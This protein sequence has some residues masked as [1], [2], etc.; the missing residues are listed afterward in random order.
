MSNE[1]T[2]PKVDLKARTQHGMNFTAAFLLF[3]KGMSLPEIAEQF[4]IS[5]PTLVKRARSEDWEMLA[6]NGGAIV[7]PPPKPEIVSVTETQI[8]QKQQAIEANRKDI[9]QSAQ[10]LRTNIDKVLA[11][12]QTENAILV[13]GDILTMA[14]ALKLV[15]EASMLALGDDLVTK[16][17]PANQARGNPQAGIHIHL[18]SVVAAPRK[19]MKAVEE[20]VNRIELP[21]NEDI[22]PADAV[23]VTIISESQPTPDV[24]P[25]DW[26]PE[27]SK[28]DFEKLNQVVGAGAPIVEEEG[29]LPAFVTDAMVRP[30]DK[31]AQAQEAAP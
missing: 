28:V 7:A 20:E 27:K 4:E 3:C 29:Q 14:K 26:D 12:Y 15:A 30:A 25:G 5:L 1:P 18:P 2:Q 6:R 9:L 19:V 8:V 23:A 21:P 11:V 10:S 24:V 31:K 17:V 16:Q 22:D 13:P